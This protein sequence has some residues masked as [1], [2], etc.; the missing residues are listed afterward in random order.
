MSRK[1]RTWDDSKSLNEGISPERINKLLDGE[2]AIPLMIRQK[3]Q[4]VADMVALV[5]KWK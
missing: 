5:R 3:M 4:A 1:A 2:M